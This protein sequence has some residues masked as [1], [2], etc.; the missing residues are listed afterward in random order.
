MKKN[1]GKT[2][3]IL[4]IIAGIIILV[5]GLYFKSWW[6]LIGLIPLGTALIRWCPLYVP[7]KISTEKKGDA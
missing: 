2:D 7:F 1:M 6:G 5:A 3:R 4:R